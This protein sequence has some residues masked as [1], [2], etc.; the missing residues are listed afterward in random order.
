M[1]TSTVTLGVTPGVVSAW[2]GAVSDADMTNYRSEPNAGPATLV[3]LA[4]LG[5]ISGLANASITNL[6]ATP[7]TFNYT[8]IQNATKQTTST[9]D[10]LSSLLGSLI[11]NLQL[12]VNPIGLGIGLPSGLTGSAA[13]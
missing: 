4:P 10:F 12:N 3:N 7:V 11:G 8:Q 5:I 6:T 1:S 2:I 13:S 9:T